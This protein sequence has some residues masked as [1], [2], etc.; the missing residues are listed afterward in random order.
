MLLRFWF[1]IA[2]A[3][4]VVLALP[5]IALFGLELFGYGGEANSWLEDKVG[6][7]HHTAIN[8]WAA[9]LLFLVPLGLLLLYFL[10][11]KRKPQAV[12]ST[13]P[14]EESIAGPPVNRPLQWVRKNVLPPRH[15]V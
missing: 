14:R 3:G 9:I 7:S 12:P 15:T 6:L 4:L 11:L 1:P 13:F 10:K 8:S 2:L 5:A